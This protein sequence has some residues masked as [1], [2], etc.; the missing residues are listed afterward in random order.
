MKKVL[1]LFFIIGLLPNIGYSDEF[2]NRLILN[3]AIA[4]TYSHIEEER[5]DIRKITNTSLIYSNRSIKVEFTYPTKE[6]T[7]SQWYWFDYDGNKTVCD[8]CYGEND[9][10]CLS[11]ECI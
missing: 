4:A 3:A 2:E 8:E 10:G 1:C 6:K 7:C 5:I 11:G 9:C